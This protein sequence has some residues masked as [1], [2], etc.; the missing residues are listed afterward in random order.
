MAKAVGFSEDGAKRIAAAVKRLEATAR[1]SQKAEKEYHGSYTGLGQKPMRITGHARMGPNRWRYRG[2]PILLGNVPGGLG[3]VVDGAA[4]EEDMYNGCE[5]PN[6]GVGRE[7]VGTI[8]GPIDNAVGTMIPIMPGVDVWAG[9]VPLDGG[10][11]LAEGEDPPKPR[12]M[13]SLPNHVDY[14]C[15]GAGGGTP[16]T[17]AAAA[18]G[19]GLMGAVLINRGGPI[20][21]RTIED[22]LA[23]D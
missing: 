7:G 8:V 20:T 2:V 6:D 21:G 15:R 17:Q 13:F 11:Q 19:G 14:V 3:F 23:G 1:W 12:L 4:E 5:Q 22:L 10:I 18:P 16:A 9:Y